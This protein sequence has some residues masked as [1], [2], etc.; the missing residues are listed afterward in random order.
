MVLKIDVDTYRGTREG[1]PNLVRMLKAHQA[2]ATFLFSLG[3]TTPAG[4]ARAASGL[5]QQGLAHLG[6]RA[7]RLQDPDVRH[8]AARPG[9]RQAMRGRMRAVQDAGFECGIHT[10]DHVLWQDNV[11]SATPPGR[12][13]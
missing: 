8:P 6:G 12:P 11:A 2:G 1:V 9:H 5:L 13:A 3:P 7:L 4:P 10:W